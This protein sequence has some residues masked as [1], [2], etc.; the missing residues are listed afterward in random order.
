M[1]PGLLIVL[2]AMVFLAFVVEGVAGFGS[3]VVTLA[4]AAHLLPVQVVVAALLPVN[5]GMSLWLVARG[6][7]E[8]DVA[9]LGRRVLPWMGLGTLLGLRLH[10][11]SG[12]LALKAVF[13]VLVALLALLELLRMARQRVA[14]PAPLRPTLAALGLLAAG[15]IHGVFATGGPLAVYVIGRS[16]PDKGGFRATLSALWMALNLILLVAY[17]RSGEVGAA[18]LGQSAALLPA[19]LAGGWLGQRLHDRIPLHRFRLAVFLLL[20]FAGITLLIR[21][22]AA[23]GLDGI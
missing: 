8:V 14:S 9:L 12:Q 5:L 16:L 6:R 10:A 3:T 20:L 22:L 1:D 11:L 21:T 17:L 18:S 2:A 19:M 23:M 13:A 7:R 4:L 15:V